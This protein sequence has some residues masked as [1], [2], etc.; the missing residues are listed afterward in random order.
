MLADNSSALGEKASTKPRTAFRSA[1]GRDYDSGWRPRNP[2]RARN[3]ILGE[4]N[5]V[6]ISIYLHFN[7][8]CRDAFEFYRSALGGEFAIFQTFRDMPPSDDMG[9]PESEL[10][11]VMHVSYPIGSSVLMGSDM[12]SSMGPPVTVGNNYSVSLSPESRDEA[13]RV[14][15]ALSDGGSV[16]MPMA[17]MF[18]GSY[19]GALADKFGINWQINYDLPAA[20]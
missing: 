11:N 5:K 9:V 15:A 4:T 20:D 13:D 18:W 6:T 3:R 10:D 14:F 19:F 2:A 1:G 12:P 8:D 7:G 17:D 16:Q